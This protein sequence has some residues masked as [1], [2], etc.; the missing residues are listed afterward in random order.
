MQLLKIMPSEDSLKELGM[1]SL[2]KKS[3]K[4]DM[5]SVFKYIK[6]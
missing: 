1:F 5:I 3:L 4:G 2:Q 6:G